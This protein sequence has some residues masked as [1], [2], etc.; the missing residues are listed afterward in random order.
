MDSLQDGVQAIDGMRPLAPHYIVPQIENSISIRVRG[1]RARTSSVG[2]AP[3]GTAPVYTAS[4]HTES[5]DTASVY[6]ASIGTTPLWT[7]RSRKSFV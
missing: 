3:V 7:P 1:S 2:I 5:V 4:P 6:T